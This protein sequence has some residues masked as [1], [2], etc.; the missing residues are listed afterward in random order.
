MKK[1][2]YGNKK[3]LIGTLCVGMMAVMSG[4]GSKDNITLTDTAIEITTEAS[5]QATEET[6]DSTAEVTTEATTEAPDSTTQAS[7]ETTVA[8]TLLEQFKAEVATGNDVAKL[9]DSLSKNTVFGE[10]VMTTMD[11]EE[12][13][14]AGFSEDIK[15]FKKGTMFAPMINT[16]PFVGYVFETDTADDLV[17]T[18][19]EKH[20]L[21]WNICTTADEMKVYSEGNYVFFVMSP[22]SFSD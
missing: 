10:V 4:C 9:A 20:Q 5:T 8:T 15:G 22:T 14:L 2:L 18:L 6:S 12:G 1:I 13:F 16:I 11:V 21:N 19:E 17:K 3:I 7:T